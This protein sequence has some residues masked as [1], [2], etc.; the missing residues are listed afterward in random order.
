MTHYYRIKDG[1]RID[2]EPQDESMGYKAVV[3]ADVTDVT[4]VSEAK[5][6]CPI[7]LTT[8]EHHEIQNIYKKLTNITLHIRLDDGEISSQDSDSETVT[9]E[10]KQGGKLVT[11]EYTAELI[12]DGYNYDVNVTNGIGTH[13][14]TTS[15]QTGSN[16]SV[17][18]V[19]VVGL[20]SVTPSREQAINV[21]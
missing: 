15:K 1:Y 16:V 12:V 2:W 17:Q 18:A 19:D 5:Q 13:S 6:K 9:V 10:V 21:E 3:M 7:E 11:G 20:D 8:G 4:T 14:V